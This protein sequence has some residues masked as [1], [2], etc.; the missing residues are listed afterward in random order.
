MVGLYLNLPEQAL[1]L[2]VDEKSQCQALERSQPCCHSAPGR[3]ERS[4]HDYF[5]HGTVSLFAALDV[6]TGKII[7][8]CQAR[9]TQR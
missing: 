1:V 9:H 8:Q 2:C 6:Q 5:R 7:G 4:T 3:V